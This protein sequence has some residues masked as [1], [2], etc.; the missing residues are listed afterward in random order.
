MPPQDPAGFLIETE[1]TKAAF[2]NGYK[3]AQG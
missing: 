3:V 1:A 2:Q